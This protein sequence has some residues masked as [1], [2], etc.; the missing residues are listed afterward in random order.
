MRSWTGVEI[1]EFACTIG[2]P[3]TYKDGMNSTEA[4]HYFLCVNWFVEVSLN[5]LTLITKKKTFHKKKNL[6][7]EE[8]HI[9]VW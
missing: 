7:K 8:N 1:T 3:S 2:L 9:S 5:T 4:S 6:L